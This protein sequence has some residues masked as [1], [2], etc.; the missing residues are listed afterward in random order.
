MCDVP[1]G[2]EGAEQVRQ[3]QEGVVL[4]GDAG[5]EGAGG[6]LCGQVSILNMVRGQAAPTCSCAKGSLARAFAYGDDFVVA[7]P[8]LRVDRVKKCMKEC[9]EVKMRATIGRD[10]DEDK[11]IVM[12]GRMV[13][14]AK[15]G[16]ELEADAR[17][18]KLIKEY[19]WIDPGS[20]AVVSPAARVDAG[21]VN[22]EGKLGG[23]ESS[24]YHAV[25]AR[26]NK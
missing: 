26:A 2:E 13:R 22:I 20:N 5:G 4:R 25:A 11:D 15:E 6:G 8:K 9:Y 19:T 3:A 14:W 10:A 21:E 7:G 17:P 1:G 24:R 23:S 16:A 12:L 18:S